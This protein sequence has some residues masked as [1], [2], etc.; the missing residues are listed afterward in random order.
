MQRLDLTGPWLRDDGTPAPVPGL[1]GDPERMAPGPVRLRRRVD[2][3]AGA[4][5][6]ATLRLHGARFRPALTVDGRAVS[7][8]EGGMAPVDLDLGPVRPGTAVELAVILQSLAA[9][10]VEDA[11]VIPKADHWRSN[12][13]SCLWNDA[14]LVCTGPARIDGVVVDRDPADGAVEVRWR[15]DGAPAGTKMQV[16]LAA[17]DGRRVEAAA[18]AAAGMLRLDGAGFAPWSPESPV[19]H[20][21]TVE[22]LCDGRPSDRWHQRAG[23]RRLAIDGVHFRLNG[24]PWTM[25][26]GT[27]VWHRLCRDPEARTLAFDAD[28]FERAVVRPLKDLGANALRWH[29]GMP[30]RRLVELCNRHGLAMQVEWHAFHG[31][32]GAPESLERQW[33]AWLWTWAGH[34]SGVLFHAW[35]ETDGALL[36]KG[37]AALDRLA[38][39]LPPLVFAHR[40]TIHLHKYWWSLFENVG[41]YVD[42]VA[43]FDK[44]VI[45][46]EFGGTYLDGRGDPGGYHTLRASL[47]RFLG[48]GHDAAA[49]LHL[50]SLANA[51]M[52]EYWRRLDAAGFSPFCIAGSPAD[53]NHHFL[54]PLAEARPKPVWRAL[55]AAYAPVAASLD[56][57]D[58]HACPGADAELPLWIGNDT[59]TAVEAAVEVRRDGEPCARLTVPVPAHGRVRRTVRIPLPDREG[60][61]RIE[62]VTVDP[63]PAAGP[64]VSAWDIATV[65]PW[66]AAGLAVE[67]FDPASAG[68][69]AAHGA[70]LTTGALVAVAGAATWAALSAGDGA[71][72][73]RIEAVLARGGHV[74]LLDAGPRYLGS[75]YDTPEVYLQADGIPPQAPHAEAVDLPRGLRA[76]FTWVP[77]PETFLH[78]C[79]GL[80]PGLPGGIPR[81]WNGLRG[82]ISVPAV[83]LA[84][85]GLGPE[86]WC[87][88]WAA[89]GAD[90]ARIR[91]GRCIAYGLH[92]HWRFADGDD[93]AVEAAL[94]E[95]IRFL[96]ADAPALAHVLDPRARIQRIDV[97]AGWRSAAG[98][99]ER[100][101][102]RL[103]C[104]MDLARVPVVTARFADGGQ[105]TISQLLSDGRLDPARTRAER[106]WGPRYD[107]A[108]ARV[109]GALIAG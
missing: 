37:F 71:V 82:G 33:R 39:E 50:Q 60:L 6:R 64:A 58:Q 102:P 11:S 89:R 46:D 18:D 107:P 59:A 12:L 67:A 7:A 24:A 49:R 8:S 79:P 83:D 94:R 15:I 21:L 93:P 105:L 2:L 97:G 10:P 17:D 74:L 66:D 77:E 45:S 30:P 16:V 28:W 53:G 92:G 98:R 99:A 1:V 35:N 84:L 109:L 23:L 78:P 43:R 31:L 14:E 65:R 108:L 62:V 51:R 86:A 100:I 61:H 68:W 76:Q 90:P 38:A 32:D 103:R 22:A 95:H 25:R 41:C 73:A 85:E 13:D 4:W 69:L 91:A 26:A 101:E 48:D 56:R 19:L 3:P 80:E 5:T 88:M 72:T 42:D 20:D 63:V 9:V 57:W 96:H 75:S 29:L 81:L 52:A 106:P 27:V 44:A 70:T 40:D 55:S 47:R 104:G 36:A 87:A 34:A 54:G